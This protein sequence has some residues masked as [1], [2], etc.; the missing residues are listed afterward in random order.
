MN[1]FAILEDE[2]AE[3]LRNFIGGAEGISAERAKMAL[4]FLLFPKS[5]VI[6]TERPYNPFGPERWE[7]L[8]GE[9]TNIQYWFD[10][11]MFRSSSLREAML[12]SLEAILESFPGPEDIK[13]DHEEWIIH[14]LIFFIR[15]A[16]LPE[17]EEE[18]KSRGRQSIPK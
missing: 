15:E 16:F 5:V 6:N 2:A 10:H 12:D 8:R 14:R 11:P 1:N 18:L 17:W 7:V 9:G 13:T 3:I 4:D